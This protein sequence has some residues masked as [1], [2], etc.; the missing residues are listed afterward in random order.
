MKTDHTHGNFGRKRFGK[1]RLEL[2]IFSIFCNQIENSVIN[3]S[4]ELDIPQHQ[5]N[6][7]IDRILDTG[8]VIVQSKMNAK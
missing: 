2:E 1:H 6:S 8:F 5:V 3:I 7:V 4:K